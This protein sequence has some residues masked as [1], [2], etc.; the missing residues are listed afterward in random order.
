MKKYVLPYV[1]TYLCLHTP[2]PQVAFPHL[3]SPLRTLNTVS[4]ALGQ[5]GS[6]HKQF[7]S[8]LG[9]M[10]FSTIVASLQDQF[11]RGAEFSAS[12]K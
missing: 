10:V 4:T 3:T 2:I 7:D 12:S 11:L 5:F 9:L 1:R 8:T 6:S